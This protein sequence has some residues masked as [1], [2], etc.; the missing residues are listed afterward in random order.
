VKHLEVQK[1]TSPIFSVG[2]SPPAK[3]QVNTD[4]VVRLREPINQGATRVLA[5]MPVTRNGNAGFAGCDFPERGG[6]LLEG[7]SR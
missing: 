2:S 7:K 1:T 4:R 3:P 5:P 6:F